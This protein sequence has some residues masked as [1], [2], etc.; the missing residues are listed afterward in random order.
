MIQIVSAPSRDWF[1]LVYYFAWQ[2]LKIVLNLKEKK[3]FELWRQK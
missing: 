3:I 2:A 1:L